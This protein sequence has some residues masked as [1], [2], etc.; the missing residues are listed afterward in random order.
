MA[1]A[2]GSGKLGASQLKLILGPFQLGL[3]RIAG[4]LQQHRTGL[5]H[6][7]LGYR[8]CG[9]ATTVTTT[10]LDLTQGFQLALDRTLWLVADRFQGLVF[11]AG[12]C[13]SGGLL[14]LGR[15]TLKALQVAQHQP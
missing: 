4:E 12:Q 2:A 14:G 15:V 9:N 1:Q 7:A 6:A 5:H 10:K 8:S 13:W 11:D 3:Q